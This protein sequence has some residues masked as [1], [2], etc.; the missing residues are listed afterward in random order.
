MLF[1]TF[2]LL[3]NLKRCFGLTGAEDQTIEDPPVYHLM[4]I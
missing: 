2:Q 1:E 4:T 3:M